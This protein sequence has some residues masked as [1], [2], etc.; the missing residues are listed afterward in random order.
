MEIYI[1]N[2]AQSTTQADLL[3]LFSTYGSVNTIKIIQDK[4]TKQS[5][6]FAFVLMNIE[7]EATKAIE[8]LH[9]LE[10]QQHTLYVNISRPNNTVARDTW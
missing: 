1:G 9:L 5:R 6:G 10:F 3:S 2:L 4:V 7:D 8:A